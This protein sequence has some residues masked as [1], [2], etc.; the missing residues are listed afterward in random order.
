[1]LALWRVAAIL[2][3][4]FIRL[5]QLI[6]R[7]LAASLIRRKRLIRP[8]PMEELRRLELLLRL[9]PPLANAAQA[10]KMPLAGERLAS[11]GPASCAVYRQC[12]WRL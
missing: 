1:M 8:I 9:D 5:K 10:I 2:A 12:Q 11:A 7:P 6:M 3:L 4:A